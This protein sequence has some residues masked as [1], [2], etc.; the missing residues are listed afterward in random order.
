MERANNSERGGS[1][2]SKLVKLPVKA[3]VRRP[4]VRVRFDD[5]SIHEIAE[6]ARVAGIL[7]PILVWRDGQ[8]W[9]LIDGE[10][11]LRAAIEA[12]VS[13]I[14]AAVVDGPLSPAE[15]IQRQLIAN[16]HV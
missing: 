9:V 4:Q 5:V 12:G 3:V 10:I 11:R 6:T 13:T 1:M 14:L 15:I 2:I 16:R 8:E 7:N